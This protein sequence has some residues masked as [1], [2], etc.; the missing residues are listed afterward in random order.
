MCVGSVYYIASFLL[1]FCTIYK[2]H[3]PAAHN[4]RRVYFNGGVIC[5]LF[6]PLLHN[7]N[8]RLMV[9]LLFIPSTTSRNAQPRHAQRAVGGC[10]FGVAQQRALHTRYKN[11]CDCAF[12]CGSIVYVFT[13]EL[14]QRD[15]RHTRRVRRTTRRRRIWPK[16][17]N[18]CQFWQ[19]SR[20]VKSE[21]RWRFSAIH[22]QRQHKT[23]RHP[24]AENVIASR[25]RLSLVFVFA[26][27]ALYR[28]RTKQINV[29]C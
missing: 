27:V 23:T 29:V 28:H 13:K 25:E 15:G 8:T 16:Q 5:L 18:A 2:I 9:Y 20:N 17:R 12:L 26:F 19:I 24:K 14:L 7:S 1:R 21:I 4:T 3:S 6:F 10:T 11:R 22:G